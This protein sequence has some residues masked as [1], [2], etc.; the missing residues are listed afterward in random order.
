MAVL[1]AP[2]ALDE[3]TMAIASFARSK[4]PGSDRLPIEFYAQYSE[5]F[6]PKLLSLYNHLFDSFTL[7]PS[8]SEVV[9]ILRPKP[10][11]DPGLPESY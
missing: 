10:A 5:I 6:A 7:P 11:K 2:L 8:L 9:I 1:D 3:I 4:A